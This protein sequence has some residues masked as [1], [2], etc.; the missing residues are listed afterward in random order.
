MGK[1]ML[2]TWVLTSGSE[3]VA[4]QTTVGCV[5][6]SCLLV[7]SR[8]PRPSM[9]TPLRPSLPVQPQ[10]QRT[11]CSSTSS[12]MRAGVSSVILKCSRMSAL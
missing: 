10:P 4:T 12:S 1:Q 11:S 2:L 7:S 8:C 9:Y 6:V 3:A 5:R